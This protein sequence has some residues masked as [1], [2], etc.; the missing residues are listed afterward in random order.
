M[1]KYHLRTIL[2]IFFVLQVAGTTVAVSYLALRNGQTAVNTIVANL[3]SE[4]VTRVED[5]L[6]TLVGTAPQANGV[7]RAVI[8]AGVLSW[9]DKARWLAHFWQQKEQFP[10]IGYLTVTNDQGEWLGLRTHGE[11]RIQATDGAKGLNTYAVSETGARGEQLRHSAG[12]DTTTKDW[13]RVSRELQRPIWTPI[14]IW[15]GT[16]VLGMTLSEPI[17]D[18]QGTF[19]GI[20]AADLVLGEMHHYL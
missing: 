4:I 14:Y 20:V 17:F 2:I 13:Y 11:L 1:G 9:G 12:Y 7:N 19:R 10:T 16:N 15:L 18:P 6:N 8:Q 3:L 5:R